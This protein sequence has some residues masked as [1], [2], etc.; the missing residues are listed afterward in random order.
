MPDGI[1]PTARVTELRGLIER[2]NA[3][4]YE[5]DSPSVPDSEWDALMHELRALEAAHPDLVTPDSPTQM[6]GG[7]PSSLFAEVVHRVPMMSIDNAMDAQELREWGARTTRRLS[8]LGL[9]DAD[10]RSVTESVRY[11]CELKI[12]GLAVSLRYEAGRLVQ[13]ATRGN[14]RV[15]EDVTANV[16]TITAIPH[17]LRGDAPD[18]LEAR[19]EIYMPIA[20]FDSLNEAQEAEGLKLYA[21]PRNTAA[22]SLRQ[23]DPEVT[24]SRH[25]SFWC[26]Q[27]GEMAGA[28]TPPTHSDALAWLRSLGLPTNPETT[29]FGSLEEVY[30]FCSRWIENRHELPYEID[31]V[32][33]K[34]DSLAVQ[35]A[36]ESSFTTTPSIS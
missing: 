1:T 29:S 23:K 21:N 16:A 17:R 8:S 33:V 5:Q 14:G 11:V 31:G 3:E 22:G 25:L 4:Y 10:G 26:Y 18:V 24:R 34:L 13:A 28:P 15:G 35:A 19:G 12:D 30:G 20:A 9:T 27:L 7:K 2:Y 32:V 6:V 36:R